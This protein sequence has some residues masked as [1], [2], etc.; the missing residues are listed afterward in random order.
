MFIFPNETAQNVAKP[1]QNVST[2]YVLAEKI[3]G[4]VADNTPLF[5]LFNQYRPG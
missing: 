4:Y 3:I 1:V 5:W 2:S